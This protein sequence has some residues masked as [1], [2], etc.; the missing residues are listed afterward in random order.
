MIES[1]RLGN[2][3]R[4]ALVSSL[5]LHLGLGAFT[6]LNPHPL[7]GRAGAILPASASS[8]RPYTP[9]TYARKVASAEQNVRTLVQAAN[10]MEQRKRQVEAAYEKRTGRTPPGTDPATT[11]RK[12]KAAAQEV[13]RA[14]GEA[15]QAQQGA[16]DAQ[17]EA[18]AAQREA[19]QALA[20]GDMTGYRQAAARAAKAA[21]QARTAQ[22]K[23]FAAQ[24]RTQQA[25]RHR[26]AINPALARR[27]AATAERPNLEEALRKQLAADQAQRTAQRKLDQAALART[28]VEAKRA[29][30]EAARAQEQAAQLQKQATAEHRVVW[31]QVK[32]RRY[33]RESAPAPP[34]PQHGGRRSALII[35]Y[36]DAEEKAGQASA[37]QQQAGQA[38]ERARD[39]QQRAA[40]AARQGDARPA[41]R[42]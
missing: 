31:E 5:A 18:G 3:W 10:Q 2:P 21:R 22:A 17:R 12:A 28:L 39:A 29:Q 34:R 1:A 35:A 7:P 38:L 14:V 24:D 27:A 25:A 11:A 4:V 26:A 13:E 23:A 20:N 9:S 19:N 16:Q 30:A 6:I 41:K 15:A 33:D 42:R 8:D 32:V 37:A 40:A 36:T